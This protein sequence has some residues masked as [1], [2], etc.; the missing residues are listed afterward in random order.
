[1]GKFAV[2][3]SPYSVSTL[4]IQSSKREAAD[5]KQCDSNKQTRMENTLPMLLE[6][7]PD[8]NNALTTMGTKVIYLGIEVH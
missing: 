7:E 5:K 8:E 2:L 6:V 4:H 1:M 3:C